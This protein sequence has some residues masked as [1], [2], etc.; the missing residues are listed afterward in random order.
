MSSPSRTNRSSGRIRTST[1]A[2]PA[3]PPTTPAC[4]SPPRR[5]C[6]PWW[7]PGG[8]S[9]VTR[10]LLDDAPG[11]AALGARLLD[12]AAGAGCTSGRS[13]CGRTRRRRSASP[14]GAARFRCTWG[15]VVISVP[16]SAPSPPQCV[17]VT[18]ASN[19]TSRVTPCAASTRSISTVAARSA[20]RARPPPARPPNR[21]SSPK[22]AEKRSARLPKSTC[23]AWKPPL[24]SPAW[25]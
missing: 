24:R 14:A 11:A 13:A 3:R 12:P 20:P 2:S 9:T 22:N 23:P 4:P 16:G 25:P 8:M 7:M 6:W 5:I 10:P 21:T 1:Y 17:Q 19:G 18:A 15:S